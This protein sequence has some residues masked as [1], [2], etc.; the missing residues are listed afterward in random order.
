MSLFIA[1]VKRYMISK[2]KIIYQSIVA[3]IEREFL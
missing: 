3:K 2:N 1:H